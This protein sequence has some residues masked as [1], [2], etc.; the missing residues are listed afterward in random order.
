MA[1]ADKLGAMSQ[2]RRTRLNIIEDVVRSE[3]NK[4]FRFQKDATPT[5]LGVSS[6]TLDR[7]IGSHHVGNASLRRVA[8]GL[9]LPP[10]LLIHIR[11][12][13]TVMI[14]ELSMDP[15]LKEEILAA[16]QLA[17]DEP[18]VIRKRRNRKADNEG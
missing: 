8:M 4:Q 6:A 3:V 17:P 1:L 14:R 18:P 2:P 5:R 15:Q 12:G 11:N 10:F 7:I 9:G 13:D 16:L